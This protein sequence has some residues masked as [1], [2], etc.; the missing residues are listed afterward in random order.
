MNLE[1][2]AEKNDE[3]VALNERKPMVSNFKV[4]GQPMTS[5]GGSNTRRG[6]TDTTIFGMQ[7]K[8]D[9]DE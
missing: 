4:S 6:A 9:R 8:V 5:E 2:R 3:R 1:L 7:Y